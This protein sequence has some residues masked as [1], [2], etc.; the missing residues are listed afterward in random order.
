MFSL[1]N[2]FKLIH[3]KYNKLIK[4]IYD[5]NHKYYLRTKI[6]LMSDEIIIDDKKISLNI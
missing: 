4:F 6:L 5:K 3:Q 2:M 1:L